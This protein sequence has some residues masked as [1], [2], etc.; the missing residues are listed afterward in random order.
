MMKTDVATRRQH[1]KAL[2]SLRQTFEEKQKLSVK[3]ASDR[4]NVTII[5]VHRFLCST[6]KRTSYH[7]QILHDLQED[8]PR[9]A[10]MCAELVDKIQNDSLMGPHFVR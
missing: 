7:I 9:R 3:N 5:A 10:A 2:E 6:L 1:A 8:Y 4:L